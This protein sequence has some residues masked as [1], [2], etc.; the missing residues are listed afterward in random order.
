MRVLIVEDEKRLAEALGQLMKEQRYAVD[1]VSVSYTHLD[2]Y[3][4]QAICLPI[5]AATP[6]CSCP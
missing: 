5:T 2:V 3:K 6:T 1:L 4:R